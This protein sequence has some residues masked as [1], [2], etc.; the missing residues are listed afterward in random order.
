MTHSPLIPGFNWTHRTDAYGTHQPVLFEAI[1]RSK[2]P[3]PILELGCGF[4]ST[5]LIHASAEDKEVITVETNR[6]WLSKFEHLTT[7]K[8]RFILVKDF[9]EILM[10]FNDNYSVVFIDQG[11]WESRAFCVEKFKNSS[12][13]VV[14]HD[15][16]YLEREI[17][18]N[19]S[20]HYKYV[21]TFM[22][23]QPYPYMTGPPT[24]IM[25]N[26]VDVTEW[27]INYED[28]K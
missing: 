3:N 25:S 17:H 13:F 23:L 24:T 1:K 14:L 15:A 26:Y 22:P 10:R 8:R 7:E 27:N 16:D 20:D 21:K 12:E 19:F 4:N 6:D 28:Y 2:S 18:M 9:H 5:L 11:E